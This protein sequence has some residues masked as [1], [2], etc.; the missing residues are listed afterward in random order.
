ME[1][2]TTS[3]LHERYFCF[4]IKNDLHILILSIHIEACYLVQPVRISF[5]GNG[6]LCLMRLS[7]TDTL[8]DT[9]IREEQ[10]TAVVLVYV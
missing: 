3:E 1:A 6:P 5:E 7:S 2:L 8:C 9:S 4:I 10:W